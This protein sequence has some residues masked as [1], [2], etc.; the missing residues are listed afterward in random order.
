MRDLGAGTASVNFFRTLGSSVGVAVF[1]VILTQ[2]L[3]A[4]VTDDLAGIDL[5]PGVDVASLTENPRALTLLDEPLRTITT[6]GLSDAITT[7][8][9]VAG[10][11]MA[12]GIIAA[13]A[14]RELPLRDFASLPTPAPA[15]E[16]A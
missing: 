6:T 2:R 12:T 4:A 5:P 15:P 13:V 3:T 8:F 11:V 14:L 10:C 16:P 9:L 1:G 7:V